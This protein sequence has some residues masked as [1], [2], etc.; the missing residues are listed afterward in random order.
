MD[1]R[2]VLEL[3]E[4]IGSQN[5]VGG[6]PAEPVEAAAGNLKAQQPLISQ[7]DVLPRLGFDEVGRNENAGPKQ[8]GIPTLV[9]E[10]SL[11]Q[12]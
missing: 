5:S 8:S 10:K 3:H 4:A 12:H 1:L 6:R 2:H 11:A 7:M 9:F